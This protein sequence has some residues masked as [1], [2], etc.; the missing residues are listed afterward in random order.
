[1]NTD[2]KNPGKKLT[3][4]SR[5]T[6]LENFHHGGTVT[7]RFTRSEPEPQELRPRREPVSVLMVTLDFSDIERR[8]MA[9]LENKTGIADA[10]R[11]AL[12]SRGKDRHKI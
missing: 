3:G 9:D 10:M 2:S 11:K 6:G 1:M 7:G 5:M 8:V 4:E 12:V